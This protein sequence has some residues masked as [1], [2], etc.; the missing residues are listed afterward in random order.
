MFSVWMS[1]RLL[2][3]RKSRNV[4]EIS[5][6]KNVR[7]GMEILRGFRV[8]AISFMLACSLCSSLLFSTTRDRSFNNPRGSYVSRFP[9]TKAIRVCLNYAFPFYSFRGSHRSRYTE[10]K[11]ANFVVQVSWASS[12]N[13]PENW[14]AFID[15]PKLKLVLVS[16]HKQKPVAANAISIY[17]ARRKHFLTIIS[18][19]S[20]NILTELLLLRLCKYWANSYFSISP[21]L[22][23]KSAS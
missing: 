2:F 8:F 21:M 11:L 1:L 18:K 3:S 20:N 13:V 12:T 7:F 10:E 4:L 16:W 19:L 9:T 15:A 5:H 23:I 17:A 6:S 22:Q 14:R